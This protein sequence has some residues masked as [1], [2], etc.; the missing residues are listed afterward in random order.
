MMDTA[1]RSLLQTFHRGV[2]RARGEHPVVPCTEH[3]VRSS[4]IEGDADAMLQDNGGAGTRGDGNHP[5]RRR[6][7]EVDEDIAIDIE[8]FTVLVPATDADVS[9]RGR[10][11]AVIGRE[12]A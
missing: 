4:H 12:D 10:L 1:W 6:L 7:V 3:T 11:P 5:R 2:G 9:R 8:H